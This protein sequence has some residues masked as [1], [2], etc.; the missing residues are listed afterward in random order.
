[1]GFVEK[2]FSS[3]GTR[4]LR[5]VGHQRGAVRVYETDE[6]DSVSR[7]KGPVPADGSLGYAPGALH[8]DED[9]VLHANFGDEG[10]ASFAPAGDNATTLTA[11]ASAG[12]AVIPANASVC[13]ITS[14]AAANYVSL[15][16]P[17]R[18][19]SLILHVGANG[20][21][22]QTSNPATVSLNATAGAPNV[23]S[24][25]PAFSV[26]RLFCPNDTTFPAWK[27]DYLT[28]AGI[29]TQLPPAA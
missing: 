11:N 9:G 24:Q 26:V 21:R 23:Y 28:F 22:L 8:V 4:R 14:S 1:M 16:A 19:K 20:Y 7:S 12:A 5:N 15:P 6:N 25:V 27:A 2:M 29:P 3:L 13:G 18:G 17:K 10:A